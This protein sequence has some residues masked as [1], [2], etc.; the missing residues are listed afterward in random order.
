MPDDPT[1]PDLETTDGLEATPEPAGDPDALGDAGKRALNAEREARKAAEAAAKQAAAELEEL[2]A[3]QL[4]EHER[5]IADAART[6]RE[7]AAAEFAPRLAA[8][9]AKAAAASITRDPD[10]AVALLGDLTKF[11][12]DDGDVD[13]D[14][15]SAALDQ[16]V[17]AKPYLKPDAATAGTG[18]ADQG[19]RNPAKATALDDIND[20]KQVLEAVRALRR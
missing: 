18:G 2:K 20:P 11:V 16:L 9:H 10:A 5:A 8:A 7:A 6:A 1:T 13:T 17:E 19:R 14:A 15:M 12:T 3:A 4:S